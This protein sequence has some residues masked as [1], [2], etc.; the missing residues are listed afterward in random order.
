MSPPLPDRPFLTVKEAAGIF[1]LNVKTL[2]AEINA[3]RFPAL[4]VGRVIRIG[5]DVVASYQQGC[6][7][8]P[9]GIHA[10]KT[11]S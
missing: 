3:K 6:V 5:R 4:R 11:R 10:G 7:A 9:G 8:P 1:G 2:Y